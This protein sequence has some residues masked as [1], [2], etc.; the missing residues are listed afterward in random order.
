MVEYLGWETTYTEIVDSVRLRPKSVEPPITVH[1]FFT[2]KVVLPEEIKNFYS[3]LPEEKH[4]D[5]HN[6]FKN[7]IHA[8]KVEFIKDEDFLKVL[9]RDESSEKKAGLLQDLHFRN[10][11]QRA[12]LQ[13]TFRKIIKFQFSFFMRFFENE[14][15]KGILK[16]NRFT[17]GKF[18]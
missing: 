18:W 3:Y 12:I 16:K 5:L 15:N 1:T 9:S 2:F 8:A 13:V 11:S 7:A 6:D 10:V 14:K 17:T 4:A